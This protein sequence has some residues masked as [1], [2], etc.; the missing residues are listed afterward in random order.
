MQL[1]IK[2]QYK[3]IHN[4]FI[5]LAVLVLIIISIQMLTSVA[6]IFSVH[7]FTCTEEGMRA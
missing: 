1:F 3:V 7:V 2:N 4:E 6:Q 5:Y